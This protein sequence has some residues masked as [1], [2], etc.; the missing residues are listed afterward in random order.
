MLRSAPV[1]EKSKASPD[2]FLMIIALAIPLMVVAA[3]AR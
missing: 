2:E 1:F 3:A